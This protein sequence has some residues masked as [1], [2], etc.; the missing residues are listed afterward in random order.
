MEKIDDQT[1]EEWITFEDGAF[2]TAR[3][4]RLR[5]LCRIILINTIFVVPLVTILYFS[6]VNQSD[7]FQI[8]LQIAGI[9]ALLYFSFRI[10][11]WLGN[12]LFGKYMNDFLVHYKEDWMK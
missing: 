5:Q 7:T 6:Y 11:R 12:V 2:I 3:N 9:A 1:K 4:W 8:I 10:A